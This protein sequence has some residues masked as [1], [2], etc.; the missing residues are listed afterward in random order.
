MVWGLEEGEMPI[1]IYI[2]GNIYGVVHTS[3]TLSVET[4]FLK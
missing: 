1:C 3:H 4:L 2:F